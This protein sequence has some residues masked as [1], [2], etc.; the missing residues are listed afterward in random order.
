MDAPVGCAHAGQRV[1]VGRL[2]FG[3]LAVAQDERGQLVNLG[4]LLE[5]L[6][7]GGISALRLLLR[8]QAQD[9]EQDMTEL[10]GRVDVELLAGKL[11]DPRAQGIDVAL[12][13]LADLVEVRDVDRG[14]RAL[15][16][17]KHRDKRQIDLGVCAHQS[18]V[19]ERAG[20][21]L[22]ERARRRGEH[23][24]ALLVGLHLGKSPA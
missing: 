16:R 12:R 18:V 3:E 22:L 20:K 15:H 13:A 14:A 7:V 23:A 11:D 9:L 24:G 4:E 17:G 2:D 6:R 21:R 5:H 10:F 1:D 8:R 19:F